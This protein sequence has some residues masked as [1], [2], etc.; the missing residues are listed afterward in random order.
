M[1]RDGRRAGIFVDA[2]AGLNKAQEA[3]RAWV[4]GKELGQCGMRE[5]GCGW[6]GEMSLRTY[7]ERACVGYLVGGPLKLTTV[8][9][10]A[11]VYLKTACREP[12]AH[13]QA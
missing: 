10:E 2:G 12:M 13:R 9:H 1:A 6:E 8:A 7:V 4:C 5:G 3:V 11:E